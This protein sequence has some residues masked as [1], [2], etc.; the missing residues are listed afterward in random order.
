MFVYDIDPN[1]RPF[2]FDLDGPTYSR[3][4]KK[5]KY[6]RQ[7]KSYSYDIFDV[8]LTDVTYEH[9]VQMLGRRYRY[10]ILN[11]LYPLLYNFMYTLHADY[12]EERPIPCESIHLQKITGLK[13]DSLARLIKDLVNLGCVK[14]TSNLYYK[15]GNGNGKAK[16]Y[17]FNKPMIKQ[18][19][20]MFED[21]FGKFQPSKKQKE[22]I[23][24]Y[25]N[26]LKYIDDNNPFRK[27]LRI[28][29]KNSDTGSNVLEAL[30]HKYPALPYF[31]KKREELNT[32]LKLEAKGV[33]VPNIKYSKSK[34]NIIGIGIRDTN[35]FCTLKDHDKKINVID[36]KGEIST[37][38]QI[39]EKE[40]QDPN[41]LKRRFKNQ[42]KVLMGW[43][44]V[45]NYDVKSSVPR[46]D[47]LISYGVWLDEK[48][49]MYKKVFDYKND[50]ERSIIKKIY[51]PMRFTKSFKKYVHNNRQYI[52]NNNVKNTLEDIW[53]NIKSI[54]KY[55]ADGTST[56]FFHESAIYMMVEEELQKRGIF[57]YIKKYDCFYFDKK[58]SYIIKE[59]PEIIKKCALEYYNTW[60][61]N[62]DQQ[63][64]E[65]EELEEAW[66][67][68]I[69]L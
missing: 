37:I 58:D 63:Q 53:Y 1:V 49:D 9:I 68:E 10:K 25:V 27:D 35:W 66:M 7:T 41:Y 30:K 55:D 51:L 44:D 36:D 19:Y 48:I 45:C 43:T 64:K 67:M 16:L 61:K 59:M 46:V 26:Y 33:F 18:I 52:Y 47:Y 24:G 42:A 5:S 28:P 15:F 20:K 39:N 38:E 65:L 4:K 31:M 50:L 11:G 40:R 22:G 14:I 13:K 21:R 62:L 34:Q 12:I 29:V 69:E 32:N 17:V 54:S 23:D 60:I 56:V 2:L 3:E 6:F 8:Q 57:S